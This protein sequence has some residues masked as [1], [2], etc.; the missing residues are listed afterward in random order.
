[1][2]QN[3]FPEGLSSPFTTLM[4][5]L[6]FDKVPFGL[7]W[8]EVLKI[9]LAGLCFYGYLRTIGLAQ[10]TCF[11]GSILYA[12]SGFIIV[13]SAWYSY[14]STGVSVAFLLLAFE[15]LYRKNDARLFPLAVALLSPS[16]FS[17]YTYGL[18]LLLYSLVRFLD[19]NPWN[20]RHYSLLL[21]KMAGFGALGI[22]ISFICFIGA[23]M[24]ILQSPRV[25]GHV[26]Y[27]QSLRQVPMFGIDNWSITRASWGVHICT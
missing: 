21:L 14:S 23:T 13:G 10:F 24:H 19:E 2:G 27:F 15:R 17:L 8:L 1:M 6:P 26:G 4:I 3:V 12:F 16:V 11:A 7:A 9:V 25:S 20:V 22:A 18:F 5:L